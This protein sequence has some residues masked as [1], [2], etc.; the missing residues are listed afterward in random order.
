MIT[1]INNLDG[2]TL[3]DNVITNHQVDYLSSALIP[4]ETVKNN[5]DHLVE[6]KVSSITLLV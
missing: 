3:E 4:V 6:N 2:S 5:Q 1:A